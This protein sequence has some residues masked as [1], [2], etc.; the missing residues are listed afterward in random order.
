[1][2]KSCTPL[3]RMHKHSTNH[4]VLIRN[5]SI[6]S[7]AVGRSL[8]SARLLVVQDSIVIMIEKGHRTC[9]KSLEFS[10]AN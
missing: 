6:Q 8:C 3:S 2:A 7:V 5:N 10:Y 9:F 1:M 4:F